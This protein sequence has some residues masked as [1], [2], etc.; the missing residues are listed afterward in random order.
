MKKVAGVLLPGLLISCLVSCSEN[1]KP[2]PQNNAPVDTIA[3]NKTDATAE[4]K[5]LFLTNCASCH[6]ITK[7]LTGPALTDVET[8]WKD[9]EKLYAFIR[10]S[11][12]VI[13]DD[14]YAKDLFNRYNKVQMNPFPWIKDEQIEA[15]LSY[16]RKMQHP[17][18]VY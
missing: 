17:Q 12:E 8:R 18:A 1:N 4:G 10:N 14:V 2:S 3:E 13:K 9:K 11:Q 6:S 15:I 5:T 16:I 7:E